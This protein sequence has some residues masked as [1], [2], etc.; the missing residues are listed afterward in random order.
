MLGDSAMAEGEQRQRKRHKLGRSRVTNAMSRGSLVWIDG[1]DKRGPVPRRIADIVSLIISDLGGPAELTET[2]RQ[3][4]T[5]IA[6]MAVWCETQDAQVAD[7]KEIDISLYQTVANS[8]RR[9]CETLGLERV[10][11]D[12]TPD[13]AT[14]SR[15]AAEADEQS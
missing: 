6:T 1:Q 5:R 8:L 7:G 2:P 15:M 14:Y 13:I 9:L 10:S 12:I 4:V 3:I 11:K